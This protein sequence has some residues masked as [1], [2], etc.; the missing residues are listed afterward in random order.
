[1]RLLFPG[2]MDDRFTILIEGVGDASLVTDIERTIR[3][4]L[5]E[6]VLPGAWRVSVKPSPVHGRWDLRFHGQGMRHTMAI[7]VPPRLL[8]SLIPCRLRE[9]LNQF[10]VAPSGR[11][12]IEHVMLRAV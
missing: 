3:E 12:R 8:P 4:S 9:S 5:D 1:M 6:M 2:P 10:R 7:A 11:A